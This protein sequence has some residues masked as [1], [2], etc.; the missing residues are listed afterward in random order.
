MQIQR[1]HQLGLPCRV[2]NDD[3][4]S[5]SHMDDRFTHISFR[6]DTNTHPFPTRCTGNTYCPDDNSEC[7][8]KIAPGGH[9][10]L[11]GDKMTLLVAYMI[12]LLTTFYDSN[13]MTNVQ[14]PILFA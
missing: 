2:S 1:M 3:P 5:T 6:W 13:V 7:K 8:E 11:V 14:A 4:F 12:H 9:C 10:E